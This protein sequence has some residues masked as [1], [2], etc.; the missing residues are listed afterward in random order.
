MLNAKTFAVFCAALFAF[1]P[2]SVSQTFYGS[3]VGTVTDATGAVVPGAKVTITNL[4]TTE[5]RAME[6]NQEGFYQFVNLVPGEYRIEVEKSGFKRFDREPIT[7][8]VQQVARINVTGMQVGEVNQTIEVTA[9][10]PLLQPETSSLGQVVE[11][12]KVNELPLN[13]RN[14]LALVALVPGV[15]P[16]GS[17]GGGSLMNPAGQNP[18]AA[19]N[20]Q[21]GG[22]ASNQ[23]AAFLDG[24]PL[25]NAYFNILAITPTQ[26]S[27]QE[28]KVQTNNLSAEFGRF[29]GG[30]MNLTTKSGTNQ[31]HG[32]LYEF[33]RNKVLNS[34]TFFNNAA[35]VPTPAF[36]QN[37]FG[38]AIGGPVRIPHV[39][40]GHDKLFFFANLERYSQR[41]GISSVFTVPTAAEVQGNF[42]GLR[43]ANGALTPIYDALTTVAD[44]NN[45]GHY[46][47]T[48]FPNNTIPANRIYPAAAYLANYRYWAAPNAT[49]NPITNINN[50]VGNAS[51]GADSTQFTSR[52]DA[53]ISSKQT[54][55]GRYTLWRTNLHPVDPFGTQLYPIQYAPQNWYNQQAV[56]NDTYSLSPA[57]IMDIRFAFMRQNVDQEPQSVGYNLAQLGWPASVAQ[58]VSFRV[59][60]VITSIPGM[61]SFFAESGTVIRAKVP[62]YTIAPSLT[63][64]HGKHSI[65]IGGDFRIGQMNFIQASSA[66][67]TFTFDQSFTTLDPLHPSGGFALASFMLGYAAGGS[68]TTVNPV[69]A[70]K[71]Y[72]AAYIQDDIHLTRKL[73]LNAGLR[74]ELDGPFSE[75]YN[76]LSFFEPNAPSPL[77]QA[78]GLNVMGKLALVDSPDRSSRNNFDAH[79]KQFGPRLGLAY[80][81]L[82]NTVIRAG[83]GIFFL[84]AAQTGA[85]GAD[86]DPLNSYATPMV[87]TTNGGLTPFATFSNPF[88]NGVAQ[89]LGRNPNFQNLLYGLGLGTELVNNPIA[90][91]QQWNFNIQQQLPGNLLVDAAYAG[92]R[93]VHLYYGS[94]ISDQLPPQYMALGSQLL[95]SVPNP[96]FGLISNGA[97]AQPTVT[98]NQLLRPYPQ[99]N[100]VNL[101]GRDAGDSIYHAFQL[102]LEKRFGAAGSLL[103]SYT[104]AKLISDVDSVTAWLEVGQALPQNWYNLRGE[105][106]LA[107]FDTPQ[108]LVFSYVLDLPFGTG[109]K[110]LG[111]TTGVI[112]KLVSG[113][114]L[115]GIWTA[116][117]GFPLFITDSQNASN[118]FAGTFRPNVSGQ[119]PNSNGSAVSRLNQ[120]FNTSD[121]SQP[122]AFTFGNAPRTLPNV[123][124]EGIDNFDF[125]LFK[126]TQFGPE[127][128]LGLQ[129][130]AEVFNLA[131]RVQFGYPGT[132]FGTPQ[133]GVVSSQL[134][135]PRLIQLALRFT[136]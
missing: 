108:R 84:P 131:N 22:G 104:N 89:P 37:Q 11:A 111:G 81:A 25:N 82:Q 10:T 24:A 50:W 70:Q 43:G 62:D 26:D 119:D 17:V 9:E 28:F 112:G 110:W 92:S 94:V 65:K 117:R 33:L 29:A 38:G 85:T 125:S 59:A 40:N 2:V 34:N 102:K 47:R 107:A 99:Y 124:A 114:G 87:N 30:V 69:A 32:T 74:W 23:S 123:R 55:F 18:F 5:T 120:W 126:K 130:R 90:Y 83:Y 128:R 72:R 86:A 78:T 97:L 91:A 98:Y 51:A 121:F 1:C 36:T 57:M 42:S 95:Q 8:E 103:L 135:Q 14:P 31:F 71:I 19:G 63:M 127:A 101:V 118:A 68:V 6:T 52:V 122:A 109:K 67:G 49:G 61:T 53:N 105:R 133:F 12:R 73:T 15:V 64:I 46:I 115:D 79:Y 129:F 7:V 77:A 75:R 134:N 35:G 106:S 113:W 116:Q 56:L 58:Q 41:Y 132:V 76:R 3:I 48:P 54:F 21:I 100:S 44:P 88:P 20:F 16:Q 80:Q 66:S 93:G 4:G 13:G 60:P 45:A 27:I 96:F 39:Y 136:F